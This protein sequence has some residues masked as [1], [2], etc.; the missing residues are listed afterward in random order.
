MRYPLKTRGYTIVEVM[1]FMAVS[2]FMFVI[3]AYFV[4][5]KQAS[6]EFRQGMNSANTVVQQVM[7]QINSSFYPSQE[8]FTCKITGKPHLFATPNKLGTNQ[9]CVFLGSVLQFGTPADNTK[10]V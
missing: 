3:A 1:I 5:G 9:E 6:A 7:N 2:G 8:N 4:N 10:Y